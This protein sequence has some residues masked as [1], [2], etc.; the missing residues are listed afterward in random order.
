MGRQQYVDAIAQH[1]A[2]ARFAEYMICTGEADN[3]TRQHKQQYGSG[4]AHDGG[5]YTMKGLRA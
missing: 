2:I 3:G 4:V 1:I 5:V